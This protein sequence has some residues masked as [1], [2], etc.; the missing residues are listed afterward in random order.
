MNGWL[1]NWMTDWMIEWLIEWLN[2]MIEWMKCDKC[3]MCHT[4]LKDTYHTFS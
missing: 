1:N 4:F 3:H 2:W